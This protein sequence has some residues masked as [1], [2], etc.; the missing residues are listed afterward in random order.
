MKK[1]EWRDG[2]KAMIPVCIS[3]FPIGLACGVLLQQ[4]GFNSIAV[5]LMSLLVYG[6][7]SQ[8][9]IASM[10]ISGVGFIEIVLMVFFINLRHL[11][12]SSTIAGHL[13]NKSNLFNLAFAQSITD[14]SYAVNMMKFKIDPSWTANKAMTAGVATYV[15]WASSTTIG[16]LL[17]GSVSISTVVMN[18]M[19]TAMFIFLLVSQI[20]NWVLFWTTIFAMVSAV[21]LK[22]VLKN[23][24]AILIA[25]IIASLVG[26]GLANLKARKEE[27]VHES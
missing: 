10:T 2:F 1:E 17:G 15:T 13:K 16:A 7:A 19:L 26:L 3:Y 11:L 8:F 24:I 6:G 9:M 4:A 25:S 27:V 20:E 22:V 18:Y 23:G 21:I 5:L 14:E 12:M